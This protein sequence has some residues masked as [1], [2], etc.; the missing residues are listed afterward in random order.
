MPSTYAHYV[1]GKQMLERFPRQ[2]AEIA[3]DRRELYDIG[4][5]GPDILFYYHPLRLN[6]VNKVGFGTHEKTGREFFTRAKEACLRS[7][8]REGATAYVLGFLCHFAL[9]T[10]CHS[11]IENKIAVSNV[12]H[13]EIESEFDRMLLEK[14]GIDPLSA[15]LTGHI[16]ASKRN[17]ETIAPFFAGVT[18]QQVLKSLRSMLRISELLRAPHACKRFFVETVLHL[19][20][21]YREMHGMMMAKKPIEACRDSNLR[22]E[23][24]MRKAQD[25]CVKLAENFMRFLKGEEPLCDTFDRTFGPNGNWKEIPVLSEQEEIEYEV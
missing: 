15:K 4:L 1:F 21:N 6:K 20:G 10:E 24:L 19:S 7:F 3:R 8:D 25:L 18:D 5:H 14:Q 9:D 13:T 12:R 17:A 2:L 11:Y 16:V 22:L 23:K